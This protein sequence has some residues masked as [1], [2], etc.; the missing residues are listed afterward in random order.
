M[1]GWLVTYTKSACCHAQVTFTFHSFSHAQS[2]IEASLS[3]EALNKT[4]SLLWHPNA[5]SLAE[6]S[7][8][9]SP[10]TR[11]LACDLQ[12]NPKQSETLLIPLKSIVFRRL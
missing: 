10:L 9:S 11:M 8:F 12:C 7:F 2:V 1:T 6:G 3:L 4:P 5:V